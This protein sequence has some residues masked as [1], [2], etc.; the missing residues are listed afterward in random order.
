[1]ESIKP[2]KLWWPEWYKDIP[3]IIKLQQLQLK[4]THLSPLIILKQSK[5]TLSVDVSVF[6]SKL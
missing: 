3:S 4:V 6:T 1:M 2:I 5:F